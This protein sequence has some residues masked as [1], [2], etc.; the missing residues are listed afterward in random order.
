MKLERYTKRSL[1][2]FFLERCTTEFFF[3]LE[4]PFHRVGRLVEAMVLPMSSSS[5]DPLGLV[6]MEDEIML[7]VFELNHLD[8]L[9]EW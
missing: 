5:E 1:S 2:F 6:E 9:Y 4:R 8:E 3:F 7:F